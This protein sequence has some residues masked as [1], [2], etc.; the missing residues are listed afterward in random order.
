MAT[1]VGNGGS[2]PGVEPLVLVYYKVRGKLQPIRNLI[3]YLGVPFIEIHLGDE[4][5]KKSPPAE[6]VACL[7]GVRIVKSALPLLAYDG[8]LI[9]DNYPIMGFLCRRFKREDLLGRDI[10]QRVP[11]SPSRHDCRKSSRSSSSGSP[12]P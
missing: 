2:Q 6:A 3:F 12:I 5:Q 8:L 1:I 11:L 4:E 9:Y 10:R 7:K